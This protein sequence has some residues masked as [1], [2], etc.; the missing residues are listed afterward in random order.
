MRVA[1]E[2]DAVFDRVQRPLQ[3][4]PRGCGFARRSAAGAAGGRD[5]VGGP[6]KVEEVS[7]LGFVELQRSR[8][9]VEH[10][11]GGAGNLASL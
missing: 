8:E 10:A 2:R 3:A 7:L 6:G 5:P 11:A 9:G 4:E 1:D